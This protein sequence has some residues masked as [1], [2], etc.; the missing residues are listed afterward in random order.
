MNGAERLSPGQALTEGFPSIGEPAGLPLTG[1]EWTLSVDGLVEQSILLTVRRLLLLP[2][3]ERTWDTICVTKW[4]HLDHRWRGVMLND[5]LAMAKPLPAA[6]FIRFVA[7]SAR[8]HDTS[9]LLDYA[10]EHVLLAHE[11]DGLPLEAKHG[12]PLRSVCEGKYFYKSVKWLKGIELL[13]EDHLGHWERVSSYHNNADPWQEERYVPHPISDEEFKRRLHERDFCDVFAIKDAKFEGLDRID[14]SDG[15]F[16]R[17]CIKGCKL[18]RMVLRRIRA[19]DSNFTCTEF[20]YTDLREADFSRCDLEGADFMGADLRGAD[21]RGTLLTATRFFRRHV[22][23]LITGT[24][25]RRADIE[26]EGFDNAQREFV[27]NPENGAI[28]E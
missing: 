2:L 14:L 25:F 12:G 15:L 13:S 19:A 24:R 5:L 21:L 1:D 26:R 18:N 7:H 10:R 22:E 11:L 4:T 20:A 23:T 17:A 16:E 27:L 8:E 28:I 9:L 3:A 6:R